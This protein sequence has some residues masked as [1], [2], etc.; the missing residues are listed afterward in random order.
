M[1]PI[2]SELLTKP[3]GWMTLGG[4]GFIIFMG[5]YIWWFA[6]KK[7]REEESGG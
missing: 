1:H 7:M 2:V 4:L 6:R 5:L 3:V